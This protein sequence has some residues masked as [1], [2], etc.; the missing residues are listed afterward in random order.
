M[1]SSNGLANPLGL[2]LGHLMF[3]AIIT[4]IISVI[5]IIVF[6]TTSNAFQ[7]AGLLVTSLCNFLR[8]EVYL[9]PSGSCSSF[10]GLQVSYLRTACHCFQR[11]L[12]LLLVSLL[13]TNSLYF[14]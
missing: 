7:G 12:W 6:A 8:A 1:Q 11:R 4:T 13:C 14:W 2:W 10:M 3:D 9:D 5:I